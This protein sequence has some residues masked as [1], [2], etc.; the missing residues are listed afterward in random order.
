MSIEN[1]FGNSLLG[2]P[3]GNGQA[4]N[5]SQSLNQSLGESLSESP[6]TSISNTPNKKKVGLREVFDPTSQAPI[7]AAQLIE[8][9]WPSEDTNADLW[10]VQEQVVSFLGVKGNFKRKYPDLK[11]RAVEVVERNWLR[12]RS[13]VSDTQANLGLT[14]LLSREVLDLFFNDFPDK[15]EEYLAAQSEKK[16]QAY[17]AAKSKVAATPSAPAEKKPFD[18]RMR[19][20]K[21]AAK[22][23]TLFNKERV[24]E[25]YTC[26]DLQTYTIQVPRWPPVLK[27]E[28]AVEKDPYPV[29][30]IPG[31]YSSY[32]KTYSPYQLN[33]L[34][35]GSVTRG[36]LVGEAESGQKRKRRHTNQSGGRPDSRANDSQTESDDDSSSSSDDDSR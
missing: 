15:Y 11:R 24:E 8:Y 32:Y 19:A 29:A 26:M 12:E 5:Q 35:V 14:A 17:K 28:D 30:V 27:H 34:P 22:W 1:S 23:N 3:L 10:M 21:A 20:I 9:P 18:P 33:C 6:W 31:Q 36:P 13:A 2:T 16:E 7:S 25:R 4:Q